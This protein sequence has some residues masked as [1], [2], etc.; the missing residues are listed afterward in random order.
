MELREQAPRDL[1]RL[2]CSV[3]SLLR[4]HSPECEHCMARLTC[5]DELRRRLEELNWKE[6]CSHSKGDSQGLP[7]AG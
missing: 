2:I 1:R 7:R 4:I 6:P 3:S 5:G